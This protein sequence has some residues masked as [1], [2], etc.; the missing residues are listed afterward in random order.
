M[1]HQQ[2]TRGVVR[3][4]PPPAHPT[5]EPAG[6]RG[7]KAT[8]VAVVRGAV[9]GT[10]HVLLVGG[11]VVAVG[12]LLRHLA[13]G[14]VLALLVALATVSHVVVGVW[15]AMDGPVRPG[16]LARSGGWATCAL[17]VGTLALT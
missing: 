11:A 10:T 4:G 15:M 1:D 3:A 8:A 13:A 17:A 14:P 6:R 2:H 7:P 5:A 12:E 9:S 16:D